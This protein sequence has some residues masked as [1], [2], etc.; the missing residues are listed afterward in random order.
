MRL[1][2][3]WVGDALA[4]Q[5]TVDFGLPT[6]AGLVV[7]AGGGRAS[8]PDAANRVDRRQGFFVVAHP[9]SSPRR[10]VV[11]SLLLGNCLE[12]YAVTLA[13]RARTF[14]S[15]F[16]LRVFPALECWLSV[17]R[18]PPEIARLDEASDFGVLPG[19][20]RE[21]VIQSQEFPRFLACR[22]V[23]LGQDLA[24]TWAQPRCRPPFR[25]AFVLESSA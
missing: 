7:A 22:D 4:P 3:R 24:R 18:C 19:E 9:L 2:R 5:P 1:V 21:C 20:C 12:S 6:A 25:R 11:L 16:A 10:R 14:V 8:K 13:N 23:S 15:P 17:R